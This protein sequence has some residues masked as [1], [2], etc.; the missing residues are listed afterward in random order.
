MYWHCDISDKTKNLNLRINILNLLLKKNMMNL[1]E[2]NTP[3]K[4]RISSM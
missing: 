2:Q 4:I 3:F 1:F